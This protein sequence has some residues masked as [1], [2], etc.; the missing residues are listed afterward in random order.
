ML[1]RDACGFIYPIIAC[2]ALRPE[3]KV[4]L[5]PEA[6]SYS[7]CGLFFNTRRLH[8]QTGFNEGFS[9]FADPAIGEKTFIRSRL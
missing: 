8:V 4:R 5:Y 3:N 6:D 2:P 7:E 9:F 1:P